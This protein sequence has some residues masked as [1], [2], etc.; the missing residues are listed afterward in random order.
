MP[1]Q[2][3]YEYT[4][5]QV[6]QFERLGHPGKYTS[7][8]TFTSGETFFTGSNFILTTVLLFATTGN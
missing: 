8:Q 1:I 6:S 5:A 4:N 2:G 3:P 7:V